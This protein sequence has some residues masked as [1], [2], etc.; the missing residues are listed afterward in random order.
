MGD[1]WDFGPGNYQDAGAWDAN[2]GYN[3]AKNIGVDFSTGWS[4]TLQDIAKTAASTYAKTTLMQQS[5]D[6]QR[7]IEGQRLALL[8]SNMG[9]GLSPGLLLIIGAGLLIYMAAD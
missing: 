8:N 3:D 1:A 7:Y 5:I 4:Q 9:F 2:Y 6:G